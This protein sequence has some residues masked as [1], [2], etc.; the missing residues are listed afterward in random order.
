MS[1]G[2]G[3]EGNR[4]GERVKKDETLDPHLTS[5]VESANGPGTDFPIQNLPLGLFRS[6]GSSE[7]PRIGVAIGDNI[8][9]L[10]AVQS[11]GLLKGLGPAIEA[12]CSM[13]VLNTL[14]SLGREA[15]RELR[16]RLSEILSSGA[17]GAARDPSLLVPMDRAE[18]LVP[19]NIHDYTDFYAS[20]HH[21]ERV[22]R[23]FRPD[24]P[25]LPNYKHVP[26]AYHGRSSTIVASGTP[27]RRP[28]GQI[29]G[30]NQSQP[31]FGPTRLLDAELELG[32]W[33]GRGNLLGDPIPIDEAE[34][35]I[36]GF[37]LVNDWSARDIQA[38]EYQ[39]LGPF[40]SKNFATSVSPWVVTIDALAPFRAP[41]FPRPAGDPQP[42]P[43]LS[44]P[45]NAE[46]GAIDM[47]LE[48]HLS[49]ER[50][51]ELGLAPLV[52]ARCNSRD[53][54]WTPAQMLAH[55]ASNGCRMQPGDLIASG[56]VSGP[57]VESMGCL[58][59]ITRRGA[60]PVELPSGEKRAFLEDGDEVIMKGYCEREGYAR[61]G[62]GECRGVVLPAPCS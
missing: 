11:A 16:Q 49:S 15:A 28:L 53:L 62:L 5:W 36:F 1:G 30:P 22:G 47:S 26:I 19:A 42:L 9:N 3:P 21:A 12:M 40:L 46:R 10:A 6:R 37:S 24:N 33:V 48:L 20:I 25:L 50:M 59:E 29:Q 31:V 23:M 38:W 44:S 2:R 52:L 43:Y 32:F 27:V 55:H 41:A 54:Y 18:L 57:G 8:L 17:R 14:M 58:L 45:E 39:P 4:E 60:D 13:P 7:R 35:R 61:I 34:D 51:R 56:T